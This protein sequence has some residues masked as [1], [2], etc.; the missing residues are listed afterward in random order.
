[1]SSTSCLPLV[2]DIVDIAQGITIILVT[3]FTARWTYRTFA[4]KEKMQE[5]KEL[6]LGIEEYHH[7]IQLFCMLVRDTNKPDHKEIQESLQV[8]ALH[9]KLVALA[10][11]N[12][13]M[14]KNDRDRIQSIVGSWLTDGRLE[15][16]QRRPGWEKTEDERVK[17]WQ[18]FEQEYRE[19]NELI[20]KQAD[21]LL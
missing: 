18:Q 7:M 1:M 4:H 6:K 16:M 13:Y 5:L 19:V 20:D 8:G 3:I 10:R 9:N 11:L 15:R 21:Q 2:K 14:K 17:L 12:L